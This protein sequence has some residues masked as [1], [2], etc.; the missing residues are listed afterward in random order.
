LGQSHFFEHF[1]G[2]LIF[3]HQDSV[4]SGL[5][6]LAG[7]SRLQAW[8]R[9]RARA[10]HLCI[11]PA[12]VQ[13]LIDAGISHAAWVPHASE[14]PPTEPE[15]GAFEHEAAFVGHVV[16]SDSRQSTGSASVDAL[17]NALFGARQQDLSV[18]LH[19]A[20]MAYS[21]QALGYFAG[22]ADVQTMG[23]AHTQWLRTQT[24]NQSLQFR[25]WVFENAALPAVKIFGGDPAYLHGVDRSLRVSNPGVSYEPAVY[26]QEG[27]R[28][29]FRNT[30]VN[31]NV[32][33]MQF[34]HAVINRFHDV[35]M[36]G[37][38]CLTDYRDGLADLTRHHSQV[39]YRNLAELSDKVRYFSRPENRRERAL[40]IQD[41]QREL[42][43]RSGYAL[44]ARH[45]CQ[46]IA[47]LK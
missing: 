6:F 5:G 19:P 4:L 21:K 3:L 16:P 32:S 7:L 39:S 25:G 28:S 38:L 18:P 15:L 34:D 8:Q 1:P 24:M 41:I 12:S 33:S 22:E 43:Q 42:A 31:L 35:T 11:E 26:E 46:A 14:I 30:A 10:Y 9:V 17:M 20:V 45:I 13:A 47:E 44:L 37:G 2:K 23:V 29:I 27:L 36:A 40:L